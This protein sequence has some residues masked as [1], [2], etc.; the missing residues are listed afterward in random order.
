MHIGY[1]KETL[2]ETFPETFE[3]VHP[4]QR[5]DLC[6]VRLPMLAGGRDVKVYLLDTPTALYVT[7]HGQVMRLVGEIP[8]ARAKVEKL[9]E[10]F[11]IRSN[12]LGSSFARKVSDD[13]NLLYEIFQMAGFIAAAEGLAQAYSSWAGSSL[14]T[15][16]SEAVASPNT[17]I[18]PQAEEMARTSKRPA[19]KPGRL[20]P[21]AGGPGQ[22]LAERLKKR[23]VGQDEAIDAI[24]RVYQRFKAGLCDP[25][26]PAG[27]FLFLGPTGTGKTYTVLTLAEELVGT[28]DAVIR[29]DCG[30]L[31]NDHEVARLLGAPPGYLGH[32]ETQPIITQERLNRY[33]TQECPL[34]FVLFDEIEK[35]SDV[36]WNALLGIMG[37]ARLT[38]GD[39]RVVTFNDTMIFLTGNL[40]AREMMDAVRPRFGFAGQAPDPE[41]ARKMLSKI[42]VTA[43]RKRFTPEFFN[44]L[45]AV[46]TFRPLSKDD[47][48]RIVSLELSKVYRRI[49]TGKSNP[50][51][52]FAVSQELFNYLVEHGYEPSL[53]ARPLR[54]LIDRVILDPLSELIC[55]GAVESG[56]VLLGILDGDRASYE[57]VYSTADP[58]QLSETMKR[59]REAGFV[60]DAKELHRIAVRSKPGKASAA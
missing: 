54:R 59:V 11:R 41:T 48:G 22:K 56:D 43:A 25:T 29:V 17:G 24:C 28:P 35:A 14:A 50:V 5:S 21:A 34:A 8:E 19:R 46:V 38:L 26:R 53:G 55:S 12:S 16:P 33:R 37:E 1:L 4:E 13:A 31:Q 32:R 9:A 39:N 36:V 2:T 15:A 7:D 27:N 45:D 6:E 44:R 58:A 40:G 18:L 52:G 47:I 42:G 3:I 57:L 20:Q 60:M 51:I 23:I 10:A 30:E 49:L